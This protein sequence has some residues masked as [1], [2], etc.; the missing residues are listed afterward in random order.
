M[1]CQSSRAAEQQSSR[2]AVA[3]YFLKGAA[4]SAGAASFLALGMIIAQSLNTF[5]AGEVVSASKINQNFQIA[6][7]QGFV[8]AFMLSACPSGW[9]LAD[10]SNGTP[11][12]RGRFIRGRDPGNAT[13]RDPGGDRAAGN[14][15]DDAF[16]GHWHL[17]GDAAG[18]V[19][20]GRS[21]I[22]SSGGDEVGAIATP[23]TELSRAIT[24]TADGTSG[25]PRTASETRPKN[26]ALIYCMRQDS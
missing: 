14:A 12:L 3:A 1:V 17:L 7:P 11:D 20:T 6:A 22:G 5:Q 23:R 9:I 21:T 26:V 13:A 4:F 10:G 25:A 16:Q 24:P 18:N 8:G 2:A 19:A 15:Q